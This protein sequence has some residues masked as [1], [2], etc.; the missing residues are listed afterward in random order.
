MSFV[1]ALFALIGPLCLA[2]FLVSRFLEPRQR[3]K[4]RHSR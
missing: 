3:D 2:W 1:L 4:N